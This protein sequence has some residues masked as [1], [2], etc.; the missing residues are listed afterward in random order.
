MRCGPAAEG[1]PPPL[2][3]LLQPECAG[4]PRLALGRCT[5]GL[6]A[7]Q[8][9]LIAGVLVG[10]GLLLPTLLVARQRAG[11]PRLATG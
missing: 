5:S 9:A 10:V 2:P 7:T 8:H 4:V 1:T 3:T 6:A 11:V